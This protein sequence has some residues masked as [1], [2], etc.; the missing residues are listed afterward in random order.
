MKYLNHLE[1]F[2]FLIGLTIGIFC[3]YIL[4]PAPI[5]INKYP[6]LENTADVIYKDRNGTCFQYSAKTVE[7]DKVEDRIKPY[8]LQ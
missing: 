1:F 3:V 5:V 8:P 7:C 2:P 6:N 4:K